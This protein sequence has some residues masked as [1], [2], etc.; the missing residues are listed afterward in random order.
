LAALPEDKQGEG[1][2][3]RDGAKQRSVNMLSLL[4]KIWKK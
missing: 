1:Y 2:T 4:Q 3:E